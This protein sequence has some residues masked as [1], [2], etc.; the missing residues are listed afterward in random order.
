[1][2]QKEFN[3]NELLNKPQGFIEETDPNKT[4]NNQL[5]DHFYINLDGYRTFGSRFSF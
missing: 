4:L 5:I 3:P 1:M 2:A